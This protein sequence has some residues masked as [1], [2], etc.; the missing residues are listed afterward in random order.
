MMKFLSLL[1]SFVL[2]I[3]SGKKNNFLLSKIFIFSILVFKS[4]VGHVTNLI[5]LEIDFQKIFLIIFNFGYPD[6][7]R[8]KSVLKLKT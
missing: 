8:A 2:I 6:I 3:A 7:L 4:N 5:L 1:R